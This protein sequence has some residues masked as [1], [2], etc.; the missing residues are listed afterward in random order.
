MNYLIYVFSFEAVQLICLKF[1]RYDSLT[2]GYT[3]LAMMGD[4]FF[5]NKARRS[6]I[7]KNKKK[8]LIEKKMATY[9]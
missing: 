9:N 6:E 3:M 4:S 7:K 1:K 5:L 2:P 8:R